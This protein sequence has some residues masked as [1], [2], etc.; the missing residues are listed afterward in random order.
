[1][2]PSHSTDT[3]G[4][5]PAPPQTQALQSSTFRPPPL[6]GSLTLPEIYDWHL[7]NTPHHRLFIFSDDVGKIRTIYWPEAV[8]AIHT[9]AR[10]LRLALEWQPN[11]ER[12]P[13][14]A[15]LAAADT[16]TY[17]T[18]IMATMRAGYVPFPISPRNSPSAVA[19]LI[20]AVDVQHVLVG[21]EQSM[22]DLAHEALEILKTSYSSAAAP[23]LISIPQFEDLFLDSDNDQPIP[24]ERRGGDEIVMYLHS[25]GSTAFPK[26]IPWTNHRLAQFTHIPYFGERDLAGQIFS[27]HTM[28]M[29]HGMGVL[30]CFWTASCGLIISAFEPK[31]PAQI[32]T[33][34]NLFQAAVATNSD[35]IFCVPAIIEAW[36]RNP[37]YV[38]WLASRGGV[39]FGGG[40]LNKVSGDYMAS[41][42]VSIFI[43]YGSTE[44]GIMSPVLP[45]Q[46]GY[47]WDYFRF[48]DLV[49][50]E[51]VPYGENTFEFVMVSNV[52]CRPSVI[53]TKV[54]GIDSYATSDL[55]SPHPT[56]PGYWRIYGRTDDQIMHNTGEKTNPG[57]LENMLNQ[58]PH[59]QSSVMFGRGHYQAGVIIDPKPTFKF[60]PADDVKLADFRNK[61]WPTIQ[62]MNNFAPQHSRL[63]K[64][65]IIVANPQK[66][67]QYTAKSTARR[68]AI[69]NQYDHEIEA[70]YAAIEATTQTTIPIPSKWDIVEITNFVGEVVNNVLVHK[71]ADDDDIFQ[72]GCDSLQ[73]TWIRNTLARALRDSIEFDTRK[74]ADN[75]V[76]EHPTI[77]S[78]STFLVA[79]ILGIKSD[80]TSAIVKEATM[81][82]MVGKYSKDFPVHRPSASPS[83]DSPTTVLLTGT[84]GGLGCFILAS[85]LSDPNLKRIYCLNRPSRD[86]QA[87]LVERQ[88]AALIDKEISNS[89]I[90]ESGRV[91][92]LEGRLEE[93]GWG[94]DDAVYK[95]IRHSVTHIIHNA[96]PV[97][98]N[99]SLTSFEPNIKGLRHLIDFSLSSPLSQP[100]SLIFTSTIGV[101]QNLAHSEHNQL[102]ELPIDAEVAIGTG[103]TESKWVSE[104][105]LAA[106]SANTTL[107]T[108]AV[109]V[110][111]ISGGP[112]GFWNTKEWLPSLIQSANFVG[113]LPKI[114]EDVSWI[115]VHVAARA[116][117]DFMLSSEA[118]GIAHLVHPKSTPWSTLASAFTRE[119]SVP[120]VPYHA[121][122]SK[123]E[124]AALARETNTNGLSNSFAALRLLDFFRGIAL[125]INEVGQPLEAFGFPRLSTEQAVAMSSTL[126]NPGLEDL[127]ATDV[128]NWLT[129]WKA[130]GFM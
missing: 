18:M 104:Q 63:F 74:S 112:N 62:K 42:G 38:K 85:L 128:K 88:R 97:D 53:N 130:V 92:L 106:A 119:L 101:F 17:F 12:V 6:D 2:T 33:P 3:N 51:M 70:V 108:V 34:D 57:P 125:K 10:L 78:L 28:P 121:W 60:D 84:T 44:G 116:L 127:T 36:S 16:I 37:D 105:I 123:L 25:S 100:P 19:H 95:E 31:C 98:F 113:C 69:I 13:I 79:H 107:R 103:Y 35:I 87:N 94:L 126:G 68:Q 46:V 45:A 110:G 23:E 27:V 129:Y 11:E 82:D 93:K 15:I 75:F 77:K 64:E 8:R 114:K 122:L 52:F 61:V 47:D 7:Q 20:N 39:L 1:M 14:V 89:E 102:L 86:G 22:S 111:Q 81:K 50:P 90:F 5:L 9:G 54:D 76:Y 117:V 21:R 72:H 124:H 71:V 91:V 66:P 48:P 55:M 99:L 43:L 115:P 96:W 80:K 40:P 26:P 118:S 30:Q 49:T 4:L 65:M 109:R 73:A 32:P 29:Y 67:F 120:L 58:D 56:K 41:Q 59:I 83:L 24:Y